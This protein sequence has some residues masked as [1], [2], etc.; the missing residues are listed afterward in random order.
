LGLTYV[1]LDRRKVYSA[2]GF[3]RIDRIFCFLQT[4]IERLSKELELSS[5][6]R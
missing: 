6:R 3:D 5:Y 4:D 2:A 1:T